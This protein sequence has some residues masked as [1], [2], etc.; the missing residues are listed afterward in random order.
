MGEVNSSNSLLF[1]GLFTIRRETKISFIVPSGNF[2]NIYSARIAQ[3]M[4]L[5]IKNLHIV[6]NPNDVLHKIISAGNIT[7]KKKFKKL[8]VLDGYTNI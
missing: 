8:I 5:P 7:K 3:Q 1:L 6:T 2:G 4:G